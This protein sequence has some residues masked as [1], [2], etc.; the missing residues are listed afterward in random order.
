MFELE[1]IDHVALV[2]GDIERSLKWYEDTLGLKRRFEDDERADGPIIL[3][4]GSLWIGFFQKSERKRATGPHHVAFR[5]D[6]EN[7]ELACKALAERG[8][9]IRFV[10][11]KTALCI[12]FFDP[13]GHEL[14]I[15][16]YE[17]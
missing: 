6:R 15:T 10:D 2:V 5:V 17:V 3:G 9:E 11:R 7:F 4:A 8:V 12:Y 14:E 13:D 1:A 16:T